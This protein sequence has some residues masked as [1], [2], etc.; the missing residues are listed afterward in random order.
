MKGNSPAGPSIF[1]QKKKEKKD[2][3][4]LYLKR[5]IVSGTASVIISISFCLYYY[6]C[7]SFEFTFNSYYTKLVIFS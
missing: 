2:P 5:R 3:L 7:N 4:L 6:I 1:S